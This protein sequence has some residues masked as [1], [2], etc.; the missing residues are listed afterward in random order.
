MTAKLGRDMKAHDAA[1]T[2]MVGV[3]LILR[4]KVGNFMLHTRHLCISCKGSFSCLD[5]VPPHACTHDIYK[6]WTYFGPA[7]R[8]L[9][10]SLAL[11]WFSYIRSQP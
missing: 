6:E 5:Q 10:S 3:C 2:G 4:G 9:K 1:W 8:A 7:G 11:T